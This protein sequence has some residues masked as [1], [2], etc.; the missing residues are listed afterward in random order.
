MYKPHSLRAALSAAVPEL[1][2]NP[3][4]LTIFITGGSIAARAPTLSFEYTYTLEL[5]ITDYGS[6]PDLVMTAVLAWLQAHQ[7]DLLQNAARMERGF[8]F[9][10]EVINHTTIDLAVRLL[11]TERVRVQTDAAGVQTLTHLS[12]PVPDWVQQA[13]E[14]RIYTP[15]GLVGTWR[16]AV[17]GA[18]P[19][20]IPPA[21]VAALEAQDAHAAWRQS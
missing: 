9:E 2:D 10:A 19:T 8:A 7:P 17:P 16:R 4:R 12:E 20:V 11:L 21:D 14:W 5:L 15:D 13:E 1:A 18:A 3:D 6:H